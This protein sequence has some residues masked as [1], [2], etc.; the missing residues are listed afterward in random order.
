MI[1]PLPPAAARLAIEKPIENEGVAITERA[2]SQ[3]LQVT[4]G[5]AYFLQQWGSHTGKGSARISD[6]Y[7]RR[8]CS[9]RHRRGGA[10]RELL[11]VR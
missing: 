2:V 3:I 11:R 10:R 8:Q 5:Y 6:R 1:G 7:R 9:V 4:Q